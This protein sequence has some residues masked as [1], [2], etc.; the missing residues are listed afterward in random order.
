MTGRGTPRR[1]IESARVMGYKLDPDVAALEFRDRVLFAS[2]FNTLNPNVLV[3]ALSPT[4]KQSGSGNGPRNEGSDNPAPLLPVIDTEAKPGPGQVPKLH[5]TYKELSRNPEGPHI[6][7]VDPYKSQQPDIAAGKMKDAFAWKAEN[8]DPIIVEYNKD[9]ASARSGMNISGIKALGPT[10]REMNPRGTIDLAAAI[11]RGVIV[12]ANGKMRC[13]PGTPNAN[14]FTDEFMTNCISP[15]SAGRIARFARNVFARLHETEMIGRNIRLARTASQRLGEAKENLA[16]PEELAESAAERTRRIAETLKSLGVTLSSDFNGDYVEALSILFER[17]DGPEL[18]SLFTG[19]VVGLDGKPFIWDDN[20]S[21]LDNLR[22]YERIVGE[23]YQDIVIN[24][25]WQQRAQGMLESGQSPPT[26]EDFRTSILTSSK[27]QLDRLVNPLV[28]RHQQAMRGFMGS[29][30]DLHSTDPDQLRALKQIVAFTPGDDGGNLESWWDTEGITF[31]ASVVVDGKEQLG[32]SIGF[33]PYKLAMDPFITA[34]DPSLGAVFRLNPALADMTE[35]RRTELVNKAISELAD[36][37]E[38]AAA[39]DFANMVSAARISNVDKSL[40]VVELKAMHIGY[41]EFA[42]VLQYAQAQKHILDVLDSTGELKLYSFDKNGMPTVRK[43]IKKPKD[44]E[45]LSLSDWTDALSSFLQK[46]TGSD[47]PFPPV[48]ADVLEESMTH[49]L[50]GRYYQNEIER[51]FSIDPTVAS[52]DRIAAVK[53]A[54]NEAT[55]EIFALQ[56]MGIIR[57]EAIDKVTGWLNE[58]LIDSVTQPLTTDTPSRLIG[59]RNL[60]RDYISPVRVPSTLAHLRDNPVTQD[61]A[62]AG[63]L[64]SLKADASVVV[65]K[66]VTTEKRGPSNPFAPKDG[67]VSTGWTGLSRLIY[68]DSDTGIGDSSPSSRPLQRKTAVAQWSDGLFDLPPNAGSGSRYSDMSPEMLDNR[69]A[70]IQDEA[71]QLLSRDTL[72]PD[73]QAKLWAAVEDMSNIVA[74]NNLRRTLSDIDRV[75]AADSGRQTTPGIHVSPLPGEDD[76][77]AI[78]AS[79]EAAGRADSP[80]VSVDADELKGIKASIGLHF[81]S[82]SRSAERGAPGYAPNPESHKQFADRVRKAQSERLKKQHSNQVKNLGDDGLADILSGSGIPP[83]ERAPEALLRS[84]GDALGAVRDFISAA[85]PSDGAS[86]IQP[87]ADVISSSLHKELADVLLP[88]IEKLHRSTF[89]DDIEVIVTV[90]TGSDLPLIE[91]E[92]VRHGILSGSLGSR[93]DIS[94]TDGTE[95]TQ[96]Q[97]RL[98]IRRG[99]SGTLTAADSGDVNGTMIPPGTLRITEIGDDGLPV[100]VIA[101]QKNSTRV[102][103]SLLSRL[104]ASDVEEELNEEVI[105]IKQALQDHIQSQKID[106][107]R[108]QGR[109]RRGADTHTGR[110]RQERGKAAAISAALEEGG[111]TPFRSATIDARIS[112]TREMIA[113]TERLAQ[114]LSSGDAEPRDDREFDI[115]QQLS[116]LPNLDI[117]AELNEALS[118]FAESVSDRPRLAVGFDEL[119]EIVYSRTDDGLHPT[120]RFADG[121]INPFFA[122]RAATDLE[123]GFAPDAPPSLRPME[124]SVIH[125]GDANRAKAYL[126]AL[127]DP[128]LRRNPDFIADSSEFSIHNGLSSSRPVDLVMSPSVAERTAFSAGDTRSIGGYAKLT[129]TSPTELAAALL[130]FADDGIDDVDALALTLDIIRGHRDG[131]IN[132]A[133]KLAARDESKAFTALLVGGV[134]RD[135]IDAIRVP[136]DSLDLPPEY[137]SHTDFGFQSRNEALKAIEA[138]GISPDDADAVLEFASSISSDLNSTRQM[139]LSRAAR[140]ESGNYGDLSDKVIFTNTDGIDLTDRNTFADLPYVKQTDDLETILTKRNHLE[141]LESAEQIALDLKTGKRSIS[142]DDRSASGMRSV[143]RFSMR[144]PGAA[145]AAR[146]AKSERAMS[147]LRRAGVEDDDIETIRFLGDLAAGFTAGGPHGAALV[148]ARAAGRSGFD[149]AVQKALDKGLISN[150]MAQR[151]IST[152]NRIAPDA[153]PSRFEQIISDGAQRV[154][155][156]AIS[157]RA[158]TLVAAAREVIDSSDALDSISQRIDSATDTARDAIDSSDAAQRAVEFGRGLRRRIGARRNRDL[159]QGSPIDDDSFL[160]DPYDSIRPSRSAPNV[161]QPSI[162]NDSFDYDSR[163]EEPQSQGTPSRIASDDPFGGDSFLDDPYPS[164]TRPIGLDEY[165]PSTDDP[166]PSAP[167]SFDFADDDPFSPVPQRSAGMRSRSDQ[168]RSNRLTNQISAQPNRPGMRSGAATKQRSEYLPELDFDEDITQFANS[169]NKYNGISSELQNSVVQKLRGRGGKTA[170]GSTVDDIARKDVFA[171]AGT[172]RFVFSSWSVDDIRD[173]AL[174]SNLSD[175]EKQQIIEE[176]DDIDTLNKLSTAAH[177]ASIKPLRPDDPFADPSE[178]G[179]EE[180]DATSLRKDVDSILS[181]SRDGFIDRVSQAVERQNESTRKARAR[182]DAQQQASNLYAEINKHVGTGRVFTPS[183]RQFPTRGTVRASQPSIDWKMV[184][185]QEGVVRDIDTLEEI[186]SGSIASASDLTD[187]ARIDDLAEL[188]IDTP[189][190]S[191]AFDAMVNKPM[192]S[193]ETL[194]QGRELVAALI[195]ARGFDAPA[196]RVSKDEADLLGLVGDHRVISRGGAEVPQLSHI[197]NGE[198]FVGSGV[199]GGGQYFAVEDATPVKGVNIHFR[200]AEYLPKE[201]DGVVIRGI[202]SPEARLGSIQELKNIV[203]DYRLATA[204][205]SGQGQLADNPLLALRRSLSSSSDERSPRLL[206]VLDTMLGAAS[207]DG[208]NQNATAIAAILMGLD[209]ISGSSYDNRYI[210][211]NRSAMTMVNQPYSGSEWAESVGYEKMSSRA[212]EIA[213]RL[214]LP[215]DLSPGEYAEWVNE[216]VNKVDEPAITGKSLMLSTFRGQQFEPSG[217]GMPTVKRPCFVHASSINSLTG[218]TKGAMH[219]PRRYFSNT[220]ENYGN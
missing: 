155:T 118:S 149:V 30:I 7:W 203:A 17:G 71:T 219:T 62:D 140:F 199:D 44:G 87:T 137:L 191:S 31:P 151:L 108:F 206:E 117:Q 41:H 81:N 218:R 67:D 189:E 166:Y 53:Q 177:R 25:L 90:D 79:L 216:Q 139:R 21:T 195:K 208:D 106:P 74:E 186:M 167:L 103:R 78:T 3:K 16:T 116:E 159:E 128:T 100:A 180:V 77:L 10:L 156:E 178:T 64:E 129:S 158:R 202:I 136:V 84:D 39:I 169:T 111:S 198:F 220:G 157:E 131:N 209:G 135:D 11:A 181:S 144:G 201:G 121:S 46:Y 107:R 132:L 83:S 147:L 33:N 168:S 68:T 63:R 134:S 182:K 50:A 58:P 51:A 196:A 143:S 89:D 200:A 185:P 36:A 18:K 124:A 123:R 122:T 197:E 34:S 92:P 113:S 95:S 86:G 42:H 163:I 23:S 125:A 146:L 171:S 8:P 9:T 160:D 98:V 176:L 214:G 47:D 61:A 150:D 190:I 65:D 6:R 126:D 170:D 165:D 29:F 133:Q 174:S 210:M 172:E 173:I 152:A 192:A 45:S 73:E 153:L 60:E 76:I 215:V 207:S 38:F 97:I 127:G 183:E 54:V 43:V 138:K 59:E 102:A 55:A 130:P 40:S 19:G 187:P 80:P 85:P 15:P 48:N 49:L 94:P 99:D 109:V 22:N 56:R 105:A 37:M 145:M 205:G 75:R 162:D 211:Y 66:M 119:T 57:G 148:L 35:S 110:D 101:E 188:L 13:P 12:D 142:N 72:N 2:T 194:N 112:T 82:S 204:S 213:K 114:R 26:Y 28:E 91:G 5:V 120:D 52:D 32:A 179:R 217:Q 193:G 20:V 96:K 154:D 212:K 141:L 70:I 104:E 161:T 184:E 14:Q 175:N 93:S 27:E 1:H 164:S 115:Q 88:S 69:F 4:M 24:Q